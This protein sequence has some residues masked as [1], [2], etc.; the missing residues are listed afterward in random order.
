MVEVVGSGSHVPSIMKI[1]T[2]FFGKEPRRTINASE[3]VAR[4]CALECAILSPTFKVREFQVNESF[5][6]SIA[7]SWKGSA[8]EAQ[9]E[10]ADN[11]QSTIVFPKG[12]STG[13]D[14]VGD[15]LKIVWEEK[16]ISILKIVILKML[17]H[18]YQQQFFCYYQ[19]LDL[20]EFTT[21]SGYTT[22][23][24]YIVRGISPC[25]D[26]GIYNTYNDSARK[27]QDH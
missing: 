15:Y 26:Y 6:F 1:L 17:Y 25:E 12:L 8:P 23:G 9:N 20:L 16:L 13:Q 2:E 24:K 14:L 4:G 21:S 22:P 7:L 19:I 27:H 5:P 10:A 11:Q 18:D 3:C